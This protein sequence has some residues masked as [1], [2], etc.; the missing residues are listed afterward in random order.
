VLTKEQAEVASEALLQEERAAQA[1]QAAKISRR[2]RAFFGYTWAS[3]GALFGFTVC[4]LLGYEFTGHAFRWGTIGLLFGVA[5]GAAL[6][7][8]QA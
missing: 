5:L 3:V 8:R 6:D 1:V 7:R 2:S 4:A